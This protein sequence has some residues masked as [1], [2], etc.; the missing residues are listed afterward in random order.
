MIITKED[1][2][3]KLTRLYGA[4]VKEWR[5][6]C[7]ACKRVQWWNMIAEQFEKGIPSQRHGL[8][9]KGCG[10]QPSPE[11]ECYSPDCNWVAYGL[12]KSGI[13][14]ETGDGERNVFPVADDEEMCKEAF[15]IK[16]GIKV[17]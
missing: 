6:Q 12:F 15:G 4:D 14:Y 2:V 13:S 5:F 9:K 8:L 16:G 17:E 10:H 11:T 3:N 7:P 1:F